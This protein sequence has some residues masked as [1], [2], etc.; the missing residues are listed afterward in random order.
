M[1][2][3]EIQGEERLLTQVRRTRALLADDLLQ[4]PV[5]REKPEQPCYLRVRLSMQIR[6]VLETRVKVLSRYDEYRERQNS[7]EAADRD[8]QARR[9]GNF[10]VGAKIVV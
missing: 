9:M 2:P 7:R 5:K 6:F 3:T 4:R 1:R 8:G 10:K